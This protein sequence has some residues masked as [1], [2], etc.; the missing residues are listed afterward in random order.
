M[1]WTRL[2]CIYKHN[3]TMPCPDEPKVAPIELEVLSGKEVRMQLLYNRIDDDEHKNRPTQMTVTCMPCPWEPTLP[4][5]KARSTASRSTPKLGRILVQRMISRLGSRYTQMRCMS[6]NFASAM[7]NARSEQSLTGA[8][9]LLLNMEFELFKQLTPLLCQLLR[10]DLACPTT[11]HGF[12]PYGSLY[13]CWLIGR[14]LLVNGVTSNNA[15]ELASCTRRWIVSFD[16]IVHVKVDP[17][18]VQ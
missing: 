9:L 8:I 11:P 17:D 13:C 14:L 12:F 1:M 3:K 16:H 18:T 5:P 7:D 6:P 4:H 2:K 15:R 10:Q